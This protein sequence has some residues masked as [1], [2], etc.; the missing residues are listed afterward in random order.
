MDSQE[1]QKSKFKLNYYFTFFL[2]S[3]RRMQSKGENNGLPAAADN[4][5][6]NHFSN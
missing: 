3:P 1:I 4:M 6:N 5:Q 2:S